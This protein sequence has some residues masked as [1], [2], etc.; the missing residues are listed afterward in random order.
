MSTTDTQTG[1]FAGPIRGLRFETPTRSGIT[2]DRGEFQYRAGEC[3][4]FSIGGLVL[5]SIDG[6]PRVNLAQLVKRA[7]V[8]VDR[9][10][11]PMVTNLARFVQTLDE[12]GDFEN[13]ITIAPIMHDLIGPIVLN[14]NQA[15]TDAAEVDGAAHGSEGTAAMVAFSTDQMITFASDPA[16]T[17]LL[18]T[19]NATP[20]AFTANTPRRL[21]NGAAARNELRRNIRGIV[22]LTDVRIPLRD[23]SYVCADIFLPADDGQHPVIMN[24]GFYGKSFDHGVIGSDEEAQQKE[25]IDRKST[26]LNSS[27]V[28]IS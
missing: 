18:A 4:T 9:L 6:A 24:Q 8:K 16:V 13:G 26:R 10:H 22:K 14:F 7:D 19:L 17:G 27:H 25:E 21:R 20:G 28:S 11:D 23:G 15:A 5:G 12:D 2:N 3:V 1:V